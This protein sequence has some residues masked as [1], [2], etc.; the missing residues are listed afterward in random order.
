MQIAIEIPDK[1]GKKFMKKYKNS[2]R[3]KIVEE[4][5][6]KKLNRESDPLWDIA[7]MAQ[8]VKDKDIAKNHD[9]YLKENIINRK[10]SK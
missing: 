4:A 5:I 3:E 10:V 8:E 1:L 9:K 6:K 7:N 2:Q